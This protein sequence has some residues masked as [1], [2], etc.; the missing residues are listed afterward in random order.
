M[1]IKL[2]TRRENETVCKKKRENCV[3][4]MSLSVCM[5]VF[6]AAFGFVSSVMA[7]SHSTK[8]SASQLVG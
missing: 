3:Q 2:K 7:V 8:L 4:H 6:G 1:K 5:C